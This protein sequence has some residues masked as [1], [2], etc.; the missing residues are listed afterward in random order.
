MRFSLV[1]FFFLVQ[2]VLYHGLKRCLWNHAFFFGKFFGLLLNSLLKS[3]VENLGANDGS[4][5]GEDVFLQALRPGHCHRLLHQVGLIGVRLEELEYQ[6]SA[7]R[8]HVWETFEHHFGE[9]EVVEVLKH[10]DHDFE[11]SRSLFFQRNIKSCLS[12]NIRV[13][14]DQRHI[15]IIFG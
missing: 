11:G 6:L 7:I 3:V 2:L 13:Q 12:L 9:A 14:N 15:P 1:Y 4:V 8:D 5:R 10:T